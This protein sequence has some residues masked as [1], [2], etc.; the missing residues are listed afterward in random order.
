MR[1]LFITL[2][3]SFLLAFNSASVFAEEAE[4][5]GVDWVR[6][7]GW[8]NVERL[9]NEVYS[10]EGVQQYS[11]KIRSDL[12]ALGVSENGLDRYIKDFEEKYLNHRK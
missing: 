2:T 11:R 9:E 3:M 8:A 10:T 4:K 12:E 7:L 6:H 5:K 1:N